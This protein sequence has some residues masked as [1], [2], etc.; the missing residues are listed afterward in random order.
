M[1][2]P[3]GIVQKAENDLVLSFLSVRRAI[4]AL[5]FFLPTA[6]LIYGLFSADGILRSISAAYYSPMREIFVGS[7]I[8]QA[9]F[10]WSYE[11]FRRNAGEIVSDKV[12]A[13]LAAISAALIALAPTSPKDLLPPTAAPFDPAQ[14]CTLLQCSLGVALTDKLHLVAAAVYFTALA[15]YCLVLFRR[16]RVD[17]DE[18]LASNRIY[19]F[20]GWTIVVT[21][22]LVGV[23]FLTGLDETLAILRPIFWLELIATFA[24]ATGWMVKGDALRPLVRTIAASR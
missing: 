3:Q 20:C 7:L 13:R 12:T 19:R 11:G 10:L 5:G 8:A 4:G 21:I 2:D 1:K 6:L 15:V 9:V 24:F 17:S 18:K 22:G 23:L 16:G 14:D